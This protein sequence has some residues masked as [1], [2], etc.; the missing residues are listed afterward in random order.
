MRGQQPLSKPQMHAALAYESHIS[1]IDEAEI[2]L[3]DLECCSDYRK[4]SPR[5]MLLTV[6]A[7]YATT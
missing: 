1:H 6:I 5:L 2:V 3:C 7:F 4:P